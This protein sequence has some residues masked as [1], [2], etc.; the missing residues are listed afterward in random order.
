MKISLNWL[1]DYVNIDGI[2]IEELVDKLTMSGLEVEDYDDQ[3][4]KYGC[5]IIGKVKA[6]KKHPDADKLTVCNV[7]DGTQ[8]LQVV[9]GAP[10]AELKNV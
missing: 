2:P 6:V 7:F 9:C 10:N 1:K 4:K 3:N 8:E 5:I